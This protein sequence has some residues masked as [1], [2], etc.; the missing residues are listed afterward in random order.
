MNCSL[1]KDKE[2]LI[3][4][5]EL[6]NQEKLDYAAKVYNPNN[7]GKVEDVDIQL[8]KNEPLFLEHLLPKIRGETIKYSSKLKQSQQCLPTKLTQR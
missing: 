3:M 5:N 8:S 7:I 2:Y 1:L 4:I 6:I